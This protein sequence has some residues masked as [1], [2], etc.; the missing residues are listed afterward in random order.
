[1]A[2]KQVVK[3]SGLQNPDNLDKDY[4]N[5]LIGYLG[6]LKE[7]D[8]QVALR[9]IRYVINGSDE[10]VL[11]TLGGLK[12]AAEALELGGVS[13]MYNYDRA[14]N[15]TRARARLLR[16]GTPVAPGVWVRLAHVFE[17]AYRAAGKVPAMPP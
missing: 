9:T 10:D 13:T 14:R 8:P 1:M 16:P 7:V 4:F 3:P 17:A 11:L 2:T 5:A 12:D 15:A 6:R